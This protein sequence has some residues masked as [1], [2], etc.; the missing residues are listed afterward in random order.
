[1]K[2]LQKTIYGITFTISA[3]LIYQILFVEGTESKAILSS[4]EIVFIRPWPLRVGFH[5]MSPTISERWAL[6]YLSR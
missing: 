6:A 2:L 4:E 1:M 5:D 3:V